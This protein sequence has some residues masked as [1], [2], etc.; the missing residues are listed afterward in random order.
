VFVVYSCRWRATQ[1]AKRSGNSEQKLGQNIKELRDFARCYIF[2]EKV[3]R[4]ST[5]VEH[6]QFYLPSDKFDMSDTWSE[7]TSMRAVYPVIATAK[8]LSAGSSY[9]VTRQL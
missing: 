6:Q 2:P 8:D 3:F 5:E 9:S 7:K 1:V 4:R